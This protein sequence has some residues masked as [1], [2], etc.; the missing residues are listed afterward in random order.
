MPKKLIVLLSLLCTCFIALG[1]ESG[2]E[3]L[4]KKAEAGDAEAQYFLGSKLTF[5]YDKEKINWYRLA[6]EQG[7]VLAQFAVGVVYY[8]GRGVPQ[9][10]REAAKWYRKAAEQG[11]VLAQGELAEMYDKGEGVPEDDQEA[12]K[13]Y[14]KAADQGFALAQWQLGLMYYKGDGVPQDYVQSYAW[15][16]L[17]VANGIADAK[18]A[19]DGVAELMTPEQIARAQ[20]LSTEL[21]KKNKRG[22][23]SRFEPIQPGENL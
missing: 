12:V 4:R 11:F 22:E 5:R 1:A 8:Q 15:F 14:R 20:E 21:H 2:I 10:Y 19:K 17:A 6:A 3:K 7:H 16:N 13:W 23:V 9:D 18:Q